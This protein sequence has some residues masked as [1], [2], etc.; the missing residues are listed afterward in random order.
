ME[1]YPMD[2]KRI[3]RLLKENEQRKKMLWKRNSTRL[4]WYMFI[5][6]FIFLLL[7]QI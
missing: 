3:E 2:I 5:S 1:S 7:Y 6:L 4:L